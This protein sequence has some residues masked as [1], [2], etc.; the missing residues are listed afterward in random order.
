MADPGTDVR[1]RLARHPW[2][3]SLPLLIEYARKRVGWRTWGGARGGRLPAGKE[4]EDVVYEAIEKVYSG[5]RAWDPAAKPD[6]L[7]FLKDVIESDVHHL[8]V[9]FENRG[10]VTETALGE[11]M[12][13]G[14]AE[15]YLNTRP[16]A[17]PSPADAAVR[18][19]EDR[20]ARAFAETFLATLVGEPDLAAIVSCIFDGVVKP[21]EI[22][23]KTGRD[24]GEVYSARKRLQRRLMD[25]YADWGMKHGTEPRGW[26]P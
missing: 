26:S 1:D 11:R 19:E 14:V 12:V 17:G 3:D 16:A 13:D 23:A 20:E 7:Q 5:Q 8:A 6:L 2:A 15:P 18:G 24:P 9:G 10:V 21:A 22:A 25:F 4:A